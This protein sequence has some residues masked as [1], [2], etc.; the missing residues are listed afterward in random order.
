ML[1]GIR[2]PRSGRVRPVFP[3]PPFQLDCG[4][5]YCLLIAVETRYPFQDPGMD[6]TLEI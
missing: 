3:V 1:T 4:I 6:G 2:W 5:I